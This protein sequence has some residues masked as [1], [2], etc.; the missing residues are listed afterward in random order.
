[1]I[2]LCSLV[3]FLIIYAHPPPSDDALRNEFILLILNNSHSS[4][5]WPNLDRANPL[6]MWNRIN[7]PS[8]QKLKDLF[9]NNHPHS[10]VESTLMFS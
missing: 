9:L 6:T 4:F 7:N 3:K 5:L 1:M 8:V 10:I 2:F